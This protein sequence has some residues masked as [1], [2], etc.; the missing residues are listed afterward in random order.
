MRPWTKREN[1]VRGKQ[2][3]LIEYPNLVIEIH[4]TDPYGGSLP[5]TDAWQKTLEQTTAITEQARPSALKRRIFEIM[6]ASKPRLSV[7]F[8]LPRDTSR[9]FENCSG[10]NSVAKPTTVNAC[11]PNNIFALVCDDLATIESKMEH[12]WSPRE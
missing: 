8:G 5:S 3:W 4:I 10:Y 2:S 11:H 9:V 7:G 12:L 1:L 6:S